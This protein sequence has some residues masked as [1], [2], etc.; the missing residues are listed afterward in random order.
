MTPA[1]IATII[2]LQVTILTSIAG[3]AYWLSG[4]FKDGEHKDKAQDL[5]LE[6]HEEW[7]EAERKRRESGEMPHIILARH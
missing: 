2:G 5:I 3:L 6:A 7:I 4:K 1:F